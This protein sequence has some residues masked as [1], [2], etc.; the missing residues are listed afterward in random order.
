MLPMMSDAEI[1]ELRADIFQNGLRE[2][3][4][5]FVDNR[6]EASGAKPPFPEFLLDGR[7]RMAAL[8]L[9]GHNSPLEVNAAG[10][11]R[12]NAITRGKRDG[13]N[14]SIR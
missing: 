2:P 9:E 10:I 5:I 8:L 11:R 1:E 12:I 3:I 6:Q 7:D 13:S 14:Y 4:V